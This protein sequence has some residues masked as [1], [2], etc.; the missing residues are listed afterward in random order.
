ML[1]KSIF[2][3]QTSYSFNLNLF[4]F[5]PIMLEIMTAEFC[6]NAHCSLKHVFVLKIIFYYISLSLLLLLLL[7]AV[8][9]YS[10]YQ[11]RFKQNLK[12]KNKGPSSNQ[13]L[14]SSFLWEKGRYLWCHSNLWCDQEIMGHSFNTATMP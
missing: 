3:Q 10:V 7:L 14:K 8:K 11:W 6:I 13:E 2:F 5:S 1:K 9:Y 4:L 12:S